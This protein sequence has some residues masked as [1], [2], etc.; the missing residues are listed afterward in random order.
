SRLAESESY[1]FDEFEEVEADATDVAAT[2]AL[3][4]FFQEHSQDVFYQ[5]QLQVLFERQYFHWVTVRALR[6]LVDERF[7]A[8]SLEQ[9]PAGRTFRVF[10]HRSFR[11]NR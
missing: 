2:E 9:S 5:K 6:Q 8:T 4:L 1:D 3:R 11:F 7:I 10:R